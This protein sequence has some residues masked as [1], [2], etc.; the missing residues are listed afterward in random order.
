MMK[1]LFNQFNRNFRVSEQIEQFQKKLLSRQYKMS[2]HKQ[3][4]YKK[5]IAD[6]TTNETGA[7]VS[8]KMFAHKLMLLFKFLAVLG[9]QKDIFGRDEQSQIIIETFVSKAIASWSIVNCFVKL[10]T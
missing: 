6:I 7:N 8:E 5:I 1:H 3:R 2:S 9:S 4:D 10:L